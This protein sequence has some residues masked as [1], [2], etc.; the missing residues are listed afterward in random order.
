MPLRLLHTSDWHLGHTLHDRER[1]QEHHAFLEWLVQLAVVE[2]AEAVLIAGDVFDSANPSARAQAA[3][4]GFLRRLR[5]ALPSVSVVVIGGNHDSGHRLDA[6]R[7]LLDELG[8][9]VVGAVPRRD[10]G[11]LDVARLVAPLRGAS[12]CVAAWVVAMPFIRMQDLPLAALGGA[13]GVVQAVRALYDEALAHARTLRQP[14]QAL[15]AMGHAWFEAAQASAGSERKVQLGNEAALPAA[16]FSDDV[17]YVALGHLHLAQRVGGRDHV[18]YCGSPIPLALDERTYAHQVLSVEL[19]DNTPAVVRAHPIPRTVPFWRVPHERAAASLAEVL[20]ELRAL[21][22]R[23][24]H[25]PLS[26]LPFLDV[27]VTDT[28]R[29]PNLRAQID[30]ALVGRGAHLARLLD[31]T[32]RA[33]SRL[34]AHLAKDSL[35]EVEPEAIFLDFWQ[36]ERGAPPGEAV[37]S[38]FR[39]VLD[40]A[41]RGGVA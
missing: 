40:L 34:P 38:R 8:V 5:M 32:P 16:M 13:E 12:G 37:L 30:E 23:A 10:T 2:R 9:H 14:G 18:R 29:T 31:T 20:A 6:P 36:R 4:Y 22:A 17:D 21:P 11:A 15:I 26:D 35:A 3:Y 39:Q 41:Q 7:P 28:A 24:P 25:Q 1:D 19:A 27:V 33:P